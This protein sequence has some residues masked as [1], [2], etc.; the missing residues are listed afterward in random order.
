MQQDQ[1][2]SGVESLRDSEHQD[3]DQPKPQAQ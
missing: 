3:E 1:E 2:S